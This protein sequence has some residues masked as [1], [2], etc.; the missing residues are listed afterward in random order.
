MTQ[1]DYYAS[2][3]SMNGTLER[4]AKELEG[5]DTSPRRP[6]RD[7]L[8]LWKTGGLDQK[9]SVVADIWK[10]V[11][12]MPSGKGRAPFDPEHIIPVPVETA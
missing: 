7:Y 4:L 6:P 1:S 3:A 5:I 9:R 8:G 10:S 12:I 11:L 2:L